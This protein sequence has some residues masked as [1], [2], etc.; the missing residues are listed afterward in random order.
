M[1]TSPRPSSTRARGPTETSIITATG[2]Y[3]IEWSLQEGASA[4]SKAP[5]LIKRYTDTVNADDFKF[6]TDK[7]VIVALP[8]EVSAVSHTQ[9]KKPTRQSIAGNFLNPRPAGLGPHRNP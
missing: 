5:Y 2:P 9:L 8:N 6:G 7:N 4:A 1:L 3:I